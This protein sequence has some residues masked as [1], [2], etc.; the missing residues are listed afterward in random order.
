MRRDLPSGT[1]TFL[2]T[3]VEGSTKLLHERGEE[4][5]GEL[6]AEHHRLCR[7]A[8]KA[9]DGV[10]VDTEGDAFFVV[11]EEAEDA[12]AAAQDAQAK[13]SGRPLKV[14]MGLHTGP[15]VVRETGYVGREL[16]RAARIAATGHGGQ[17]VL[18]QATKSLLDERF[19]FTS[20]GEHRLKDFPDPIALYQLGEEHFPPLRTISNTNLPRP[21]SSFIGRDREL[22]E[23]LATI[24]HGARLLTLTGPGGSGKTRLAL[25]AAT[26]LVSTYKAG[27][28]WVGLASL[29]DPSLVSEQIA[30]TLGAKADL[31]AYIGERQMLLLLDNLEQVV[32]VAP[33]LSTLLSSCANLTLLCTSRELLRVQGEVQY[34]VPPLASPEAVS[35]FC[36][37][38]GL[39]HGPEITELCTR[40]DNLPLAV[41]LAATRTTALTPAQIC[42]RLSQRLDL[43]KGGRDADPRQQTLRATIDWSYELL[44]EEEQRL[45]R[46]LSVFAG[47][48]AFEMAE[49]IAGSGLDT[50]QSLCEKSLVRFTNRRYWMLETIREY[51]AEKLQEAGKVSAL[52]QRHA[53]YFAARA[54]KML[55]AGRWTAGPEAFDDIT[56]DL[57]NFRAALR[58]VLEEGQAAAALRLGITLHFFWLARSHFRDAIRWLNSAPLDDESVSV[59]VRASALYVAGLIALRVLDDV[60]RAEPLFKASLDLLEELHDPQRIGAALAR[61]GNCAH[62]RGDLER[63]LGLYN[64]ALRVWEESGDRDGEANALHLIGEAYRDL[65]AYDE[66]QR[67]LERAASLTRE[68]TNTDQ[69]RNTLHSLGDLA[70]DRGDYENAIRRYRES[71]E[72]NMKLEGKREEVYCVAG[73]GSVLAELGWSAL[74]VELWGW[75]EAQEADLG[76]RMLSIERQRYKRR[77]VAARAAIGDARFA[78]AYEDGATLPRQAALDRALAAHRELV[79]Y[80]R[81]RRSPHI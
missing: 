47:G 26:T 71:L 31:A 32:E 9:H 22:Q 64:H 23:V 72:L 39:D 52:R 14:R 74:A 66:G 10:E 42:E 37:R 69:L 79:Q 67:Y 20:L 61:L 17:V 24:E 16:H 50:L 28:F 62:K 44:A 19:A 4:A 25:E 27:V 1:V 5:Y 34:A 8:W 45:F 76:F 12:V 6:L 38:S 15:V 51:A 40:L 77:M 57:P 29:R 58:W 33:E 60:D 73:I 75:A 55:K 70:L 46:G 81:A 80:R 11:F 65:K 54:M 36:A 56:R 59:D 30:E 68:L 35:L 43:L 53:D 78:V 21:V 41:E 18:S 2:F 48:C 13:L 3:D 63:S 49:E 7:Q